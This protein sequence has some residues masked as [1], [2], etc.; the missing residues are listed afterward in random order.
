MRTRIFLY[1]VLISTIGTLVIADDLSTTGIMKLMSGTWTND[2][3]RDVGQYGKFTINEDGQADMYIEK[4]DTEPARSGELVVYDVWTDAEANIW[5][6]C[7]FYPGGYFEGADQFVFELNRIS[8]SGNI[9]EYVISYHEY[10]TEIDPE[11]FFYR[12]YHR[13]E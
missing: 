10:P 8:N 5:F 11:G 4:S 13:Q 1:F 12:T 2:E 7:G 3:Y 9:W 6:K